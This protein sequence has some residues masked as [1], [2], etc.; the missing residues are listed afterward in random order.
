MT[1]Y[2]FLKELANNNLNVSETARKMHYHRNNI[3]YHVEKIKEETGLNPVKFYDMIK[4]L[5]MFKEND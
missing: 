4:L 3:V 5:H 1:R 2:E